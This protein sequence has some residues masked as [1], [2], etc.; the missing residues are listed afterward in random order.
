Q[1][2]HRLGVHFGDSDAV[3][4]MEKIAKNDKLDARQRIEALQALGLARLERSIEPLIQLTRSTAP[5]EV[6]REALRSLATF[7]NDKISAALL[8][9]W[10]K[11]PRELRTE[12][13]GMLCG[14]KSWAG[15]LIDALKKGTITKQDL[16]ENDVRRILAHNDAELTKKVESVWGKLRER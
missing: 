11:L 15:A 16:S 10:P 1:R 14:R 6:K 13:V 7:G 8:L 2:A 3:E 4:A 5:R 12:V 9:D